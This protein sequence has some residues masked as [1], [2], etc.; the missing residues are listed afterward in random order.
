MELEPFQPS[1]AETCGDVLK[2]HASN[3]GSTT[4]GTA[5]SAMSACLSFSS[6]RASRAGPDSA[7]TPSP[8]M[9]E[10]DQCVLSVLPVTLQKVRR[11]VVATGV[12]VRMQQ[13]FRLDVSNAERAGSLQ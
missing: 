10:D 9:V 6:I 5:Q 8:R 3:S 13:N 11:T 4:R 7:G 1:T 2:T 12:V